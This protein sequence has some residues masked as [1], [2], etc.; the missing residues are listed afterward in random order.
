MS[1]PTFKVTAVVIGATISPISYSLRDPPAKA[2]EAQHR[3][4]HS[5][6]I[7]HDALDFS[8]AQATIC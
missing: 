1:A 6:D 3:K 4:R 7:L 8:S 5:Y 2:G